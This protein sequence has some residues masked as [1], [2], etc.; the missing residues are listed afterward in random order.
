MGRERHQRSGYLVGRRVR[1]AGR[2]ALAGEGGAAGSEAV[3]GGQAG[4]E[5]PAGGGGPRWGPGL[6]PASSGALGSLPAPPAGWEQALGR[7]QQVELVVC[8]H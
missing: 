3:M 5:V 2:R 7:G 6:G 1:A 4:R 8:A